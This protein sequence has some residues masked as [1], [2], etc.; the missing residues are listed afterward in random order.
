M[1]QNP[2]F[3]DKRTSLLVSHDE[4]RAADELARELISHFPSVI[5]R[6]IVFVCI[7][8]DRSIGDSLGPL[9][10]TLLQEKNL[11]SFNIYG[12]LDEPIHAM[13]LKEKLKIINEK[14]FY[15]F[16]IGIDACLGRFKNIGIIEIGAGPIKPGS[17][18]KKEL[19]SVGHM[20]ITGI[21]NVGGFMEYQILQNTRL[22][23]VLQMAKTI[24]NGIYK[25]HL[26]FP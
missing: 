6:P 13:N 18:V 3:L 2:P 9:V 22:S 10:G 20:H 8:T 12:S 16:M 21:V 26:S 25:A 11:R 1:N 5:S 19:P 15:P 4:K 23:L 14:H 7:G 17:A 24:A